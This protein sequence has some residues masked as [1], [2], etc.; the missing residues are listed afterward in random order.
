MATPTSQRGDVTAEDRIS[1]RSKRMRRKEEKS[2]WRK[3][4]DRR[5]SRKRRQ[6]Q[7]NVSSTS[8]FAQVASAA[9]NMLTRLLHVCQVWTRLL[10]KPAH[11]SSRLRHQVSKRI[12]VRQL[13]CSV[14]WWVTLAWCRTNNPNNPMAM[15]CPPHVVHL[16]CLCQWSFS[17]VWFHFKSLSVVGRFSE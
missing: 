12:S 17:W 1:R 8:Y 14:L 9:A 4:T 15:Y 7:K 5:W 13:R 16:W 6:K 11:P 3:R 10:K 2:S